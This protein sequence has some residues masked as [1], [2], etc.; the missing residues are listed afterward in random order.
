M[1]FLVASSPVNPDMSELILCIKQRENNSIF[2]EMME[3]ISSL[4]GAY[5]E[6]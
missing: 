1:F 4:F 5:S 2:L 6:I 3:V